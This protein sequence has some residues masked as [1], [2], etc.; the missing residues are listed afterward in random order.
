MKQEHS[1]RRSFLWVTAAYVLAL[2][3]GALCAALLLGRGASLLASLMWADLV[4]T[5]VV[6]GFSY[7]FSNSSFYDPYWSVIPIAIAG[8]LAWWGR[9]SGADAMRAILLVTAVTLWG[10]RLTYNW[11]RGWRGRQEQDWRYDQ[12]AE[13]TGPWY[14]LVSLTGIHLFPTL[15]VFLGCLPLFPALTM[16]G[17]ELNVLDALAFLLALA[18]TAIEL[19]ADD[20]LRA[21]RQR[22]PGGKATMTKGLWAYSRHPNYFGEVLFWWALFLFG[23]AARPDLLWPLAGAVSITLLFEFI[24]IPMI[25]RR[26]VARRP[27]YREATAG[28]PRM[29]PRPWPRRS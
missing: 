13:Q 27:D 10:V 14:W 29:I 16:P 25:E 20:Q 12:L 23:I 22:H 2:S 4:G 5:L 21:F 26:M 1:R 3:A 8:F 11:A 24:S 7:A 18:A 19:L 9:D 6:F 28:I 15:L 17:R